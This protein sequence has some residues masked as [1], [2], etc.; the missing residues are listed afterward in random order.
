MSG[1]GLIG[2]LGLDDII[3]RRDRKH[4]DDDGCAKEIAT[5]AAIANLK[6]NQVQEG[7]V[8]AAAITNSK[9]ATLAEARILAAAITNAKDATLAESRIIGAAI[10]NAKEE[11]VAEA[12]AL[13]MGLCE[14][15]DN[16]KDAL[17][18]QTIQGL[19]NTEAIKAQAQAFQIAN[20]NKFDA[21]SAEGTRNT[22]AILARINQTEV[23]QLRDS[24]HTERRRV[25]ARELEINVTNSNTSIQQQLQAQ[26]QAQLQAQWQAKAD[27]DRKFDLLFSQVAKA[28]QDIIN[29]GGYMKD[30]SQTAN[31]TNIK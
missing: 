25:D 14:I 9:D 22:A 1:F 31:P 13:A 29:V 12:R 7:R 15:K 10:A 26:S 24:L 19:Q 6:D 20:D 5:L 18:A 23:D 2:L 30:S 11:N 28:S 8:L 4:G 17:Y 16:V 21:L 27:A 3:G